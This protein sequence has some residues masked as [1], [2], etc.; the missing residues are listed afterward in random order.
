MADRPIVAITCANTA[1]GPVGTI[2]DWTT[3]DSHPLPGGRQQIADAVLAGA[4]PRGLPGTINEV[5]ALTRKSLA[6]AR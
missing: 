1:G 3:D 4:G 5:Q 6:A 2:A